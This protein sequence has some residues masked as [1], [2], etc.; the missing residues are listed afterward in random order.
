[1][2]LF[3]FELLYKALGDVLYCCTVIFSRHKCE[4][5]KVLSDILLF[6]VGEW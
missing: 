1:M 2:Q 4:S 6:Y 5:I 3:S